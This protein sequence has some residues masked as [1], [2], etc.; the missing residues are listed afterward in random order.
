MR[1]ENYYNLVFG[2]VVLLLAGVSLITYWNVNGYMEEVKWIRH[3]NKVI[4]QVEIVLSIV[5]DS[6]TGHRGYQLTRDTVFLKPY[7]SSIESIYS[8]VSK[9]DSLF[10]DEV[11]QK[12]RG[13]SLRLLIDKQYRII[14]TIL[15]NE[16]ESKRFIDRYEI[17]LLIVGRENMDRIRNICGRMT[18]YENEVLQARLTQEYDL[19]NIAP[20]TLL[21]SGLVVLGVAGFLFVRIIDELKRRRKTEKELNVKI[22]ELDQ[23]EK[24]Y[25]SLFERSIDP[26]FLADDKFNM[27]DANSSLQDLFGYSYDEA[28][29]LSLNELF[30]D[31]VEFALFKEKLELDN[32]VRDFEVTLKDNNGK[33]LVS[34]IN[35]VRIVDTTT[36][37][38]Y[39]GIIHDMTMRKKVE[40]ELIQAEKLSTTGKIARTIAH[41]V[42][43][44]L[45]NLNLA[46][47]QLKDEFT[48]NENTKVYTDIVERNLG[49]IEELISELLRSSRPKELQLEETPLSEV[50]NET[51]DL[52]KDRINLHEMELIKEISVGLPIVLVDKELVKI[53]LVNIMV[54]AIEA[55]EPETGVLS[56]TVEPEDDQVVL[57]IADNGKGIPEE[58]LEKLFDPFYSAKQ[59]GMGLGLTSTQNILNSHK[60]EIEVQSKVGVGTSF[61]ITF[62][63]VV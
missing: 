9:L 50:L 8:E 24:R 56:V 43:N 47:D 39:Q 28:C 17:N 22:K 51:I 13:D 55:M 5:K 49:R 36:Q 18:Q 25:R 59:G 61:Y 2:G 46:L 3:S 32:H 10:L 26:I 62:S 30:I 23:K 31:K 60:I 14:K 6:E 7:K 11:S 16:K 41:E 57:I 29:S 4:A 21:L 63:V 15:E 37:V 34:L 12:K 19:K 44:P 54:N 35:C 58:E 27:M 53:A 45:T 1:R 20:F 42:R 40:R 48:A 52:I 33:K 38:Y